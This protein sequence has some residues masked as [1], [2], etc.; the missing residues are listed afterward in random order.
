MTSLINHLTVCCGNK[1]VILCSDSGADDELQVEAQ[2]LTQSC[3]GEAKYPPHFC[4]Y[5]LLPG[6]IYVLYP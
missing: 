5:P 4:S 6:T 3:C 2:P 1:M